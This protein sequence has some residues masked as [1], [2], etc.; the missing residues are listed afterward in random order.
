MLSKCTF[1][2]NRPDPVTRREKLFQVAFLPP[3][4]NFKGR[5]KEQTHLDLEELIISS[6]LPMNQK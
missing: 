5:R 1:H 2:L 6:L 4:W 3:P